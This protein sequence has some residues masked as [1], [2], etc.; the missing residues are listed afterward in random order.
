MMTGFPAELEQDFHKTCETFLKFPFTYCHVFTYSERDGTAASK[1][2]DHIPME[3]RREKEFA[4]ASAICIQKDGL[5]H[6]FSRTRS[7]SFTRK[8]KE[9]LLQ[10]L[11]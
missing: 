6:Q 3:E 7:E 2:K 4:P 5:A 10:W 8:S 9:W 11:Y 1:A